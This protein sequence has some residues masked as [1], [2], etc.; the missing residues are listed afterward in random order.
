MLRAFSSEVFDMELKLEFWE[1]RGFKT[2]KVT[3]E[4][5]WKVSSSKD[6]LM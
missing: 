2:D 3:F 4:V 6:I 1:E 5:V